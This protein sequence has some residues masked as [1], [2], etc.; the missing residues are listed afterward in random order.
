MELTTMSPASHSKER[1]FTLI[2]VLIAIFIL[3][4]GLFGVMALI[5][6]GIRQ[7][8]QIIKTTTGAI[9]AETPIAYASYKYPAGNTGG[10]DCDIYDIAKFIS[11]TTTST[12]YFY[13]A[14]GTVTVSGSPRYGWTAALVP[15]DMN[16]PPDGTS[17]T[18]GETYLFRQQIALYKDYAVSTG[19][20]SFMYNNSTLYGVSNINNITVNSFICNTNNH[21]WY[22]VTKVNTSSG[23]VTI[24]Q[25]YEYEYAMSTQYLATDTIVDIYNTIITPH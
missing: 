6:V 12:C 4:I 11:G 10:A 24:K 7:T 25:P 23:M 16:T 5:P 9:S 8:D 14:T 3:A 2:E 20:A 19:T 18:I 21:I 1:G 15:L 13:P 22:R 17:N